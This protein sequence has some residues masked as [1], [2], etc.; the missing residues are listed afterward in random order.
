MAQVVVYDPDSVVVPFRVTQYLQSADTPAYT[1]NPNTLINPDLSGVQ[2]V[3]YLYWKYIDPNIVEMSASEKQSIDEHLAKNNN[4][5]IKVRVQEEDSDPAKQTGGHFLAYG[6]THNVPA[7]VGFS[8][9]DFSFP[10]PVALMAFEF[11]PSVSLE[12]DFFTVKVAPG[13][14]VGAITQAVNS[15][16]T[17]INVDSTA[18]NALKVGYEFGITDGSNSEN[19]GKVIAVDK[20]NST[21]TLSAGV[22]NNYLVSSPTTVAMTVMLVENFRLHGTTTVEVGYSKIGGSFIPANTIIRLEYQNTTSSP[23]T[24]SGFLELLY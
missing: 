23:K 5:E 7:A 15:G 13:T 20:E 21:V 22:V 9:L 17:V 12:G 16:D 8:Q 11:I 6:I 1:G 10:F 14:T 19:P 24:F 18:I 2:N 3:N 4:E